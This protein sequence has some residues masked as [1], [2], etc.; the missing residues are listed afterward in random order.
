MTQSRGH[1]LVATTFSMLC[2]LLVS[3]L[4]AGCL[5]DPDEEKNRKEQRDAEASARA[6]GWVEP[7]M[8]PEAPMP[9]RD[10]FQP[11][12]YE[13]SLSPG[14]SAAPTTAPTPDPEAV[15]VLIWK[16]GNDGAIDGGNGK[17]PNVS[18]DRAYTIT[19]VCT[20]HWNNGAGGTSPGFISLVAA[21]G[22]T[23]GPWQAELVNGVYR[24]VVPNLVMPAGSYTL[25]DSEPATWSQNSGSNGTGMG[26]A[27][28]VPAE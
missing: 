25:S 23:Y 3:G 14:T 7:T 11:L 20:Y 12:Y 18:Q 13:E 6:S 22:V 19:Q 26:W 10:P 28:G 16:A 21:D 27:Y 24:C 1:R 5:A 8:P 9:T 15:P 17:P 2:L 4:V